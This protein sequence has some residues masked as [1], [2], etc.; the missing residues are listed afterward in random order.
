MRPFIATFILFGVATGQFFV[1]EEPTFEERFGRPCHL[2]PGNASLCVPTER[3]PMLDTLIGNLRRPIPGDVSNIIVDS[4]FCPFN[5]DKEEV[6][7]PFDGIVN[8][9]PAQRTA[10]RNKDKCSTQSGESASCVGVRECR[11]LLQLLTNLQRPFPPEALQ[12]I[13]S[14]FLCG[15]DD[16]RLPKVCCPDAAILQSTTTATPAPEPPTDAE[17]FEGHPNRKVLAPLDDCGVIEE[18]LVKIVNGFDA[19]IGQF[20]WLANL[21][22]QL[23]NRG[24]IDFKCGGALIGRRYVL[25]A[26]HCVTQL[27]GSFKL[28]SVRLGEHQLST[29]IDCDDGGQSCNDPPQNF[30]A[31]EII[32]HPDYNK[33]NQYQNDIALIRL[34]RE[35]V[36]SDYVRPICLPFEDAIDEAYIAEDS[37]ISDSTKKLNQTYVA[38]WGATE[39]RGRNPADILQFLNVT[40]FDGQKCKEVYE[41]RGGKIDPDSQLCAGG[42]KGRDSCVGDSGSALMREESIPLSRDHKK[43]GLY[44]SRLIGVVSF[45]PRLCGTKGVPGVYAKVRH[46]LP[47]ILENV[48]EA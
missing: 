11:P 1:E 48:R 22:Y 7:C 44:Y 16:Q 35:A 14:G 6:C 28:A 15:F 25:T 31:E 34:N 32:F 30:E 9:K 2:P 33:P 8:P 42:E 24:E 5:G 3:C 39:Q 27:P 18:P 29:D 43:S 46:Y 12:T 19:F 4:F 21:G 10:V 36:Y 47:W 13:R 38:G 45:G 40:V 17:I 26:A 20:P 23:G 41:N 37:S